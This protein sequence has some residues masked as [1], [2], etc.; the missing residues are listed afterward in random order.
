MWVSSFQP[1]CPWRPHPPFSQGLPFKHPQFPLPECLLPAL[2]RTHW[3]LV[4]LPS[5]AASP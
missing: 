3:G 4:S 2:P 1:C 5:E